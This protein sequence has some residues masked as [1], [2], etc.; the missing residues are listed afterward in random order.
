MIICCDQYTRMIWHLFSKMTCVLVSDGLLW[1]LWSLYSNSFLFFFSSCFLV[2]M[3]LRRQHLKTGKR[4][5][6]LFAAHPTC[7]IEKQQHDEWCLSSF[8]SM[9]VFW[10]APDSWFILDAQTCLVSSWK[11]Y[12]ICTF[13]L[14]Q[15]NRWETLWTTVIFWLLALQEQPFKN[16]LKVNLLLLRIIAWTKCE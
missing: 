13:H 14:C 8:F 2:L 5:I 11:H 16:A 3:L 9:L 4:S 12:A 7:F 10:W 1:I 15:W 6:Y